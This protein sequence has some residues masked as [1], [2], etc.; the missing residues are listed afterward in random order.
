[1]IQTTPYDTR[2]NTPLH[3]KV[4]TSTSRSISKYLKS[5]PK[6]WLNTPNKNGCTPIFYAK[7]DRCYRVLLRAGA[8]WKVRDK[9]G[10]TVLHYAVK[11]DRI[12]LV[13]E[14]VKSITPE[15]M[16]HQKESS[17]PAIYLIRTIKAFQTL[18]STSLSQFIEE[19]DDF[20]EFMK[21]ISQK[22]PSLF[23]EVAEDLISRKDFYAERKQQKKTNIIISLL[24]SDSEVYNIFFLKVLFYRDYW[25]QNFRENDTKD[26]LF[27]FQQ[28]KTILSQKK[29][30]DIS[31]VGFFQ[32]YAGI[33]KKLWEYLLKT[34]NQY[35]DP[36]INLV[37]EFALIKE[38]IN[39]EDAFIAFIK[40]LFL[41]VNKN[42]FTPEKKIKILTLRRNLLNQIMQKMPTYIFEGL[43]VINFPK[44]NHFLKK[45]Y[46]SELHLG[47]IVD[48]LLS[49]KV[50]CNADELCDAVKVLLITG[51]RRKG[52]IKVIL[53]AIKSGII[54][55]EECL[56]R[57]FYFIQNA[58]RELWKCDFYEVFIGYYFLL[59]KK[60]YTP[61]Y[62]PKYFNGK[63]E[64]AFIKRISKCICNC[65]STIESNKI[66]S[67]LSP[68]EL[69]LVAKEIFSDK[70]L[71]NTVN[72]IFIHTYQKFFMCYRELDF[73]DYVFQFLGNKMKAEKTGLIIYSYYLPIIAGLTSKE[74][75]HFP[76]LLKA[77]LDFLERKTSESRFNLVYCSSNFKK[78]L[79]SHL[80]VSEYLPDEITE[81]YL[82]SL[83]FE[84]MSNKKDHAKQMRGKRFHFRN[85]IFSSEDIIHAYEEIEKAVH[86]AW[87]NKEEKFKNLCGN[88]YKDDILFSTFVALVD[89]IK[90]EDFS[91]I[92]PNVGLSIFTGLLTNP[93]IDP[94]NFVQ[95]FIDTKNPSIDFSNLIRL[96]FTKPEIGYEF[97]K[98]ALKI[99]SV[100]IG[101]AGWSRYNYAKVLGMMLPGKNSKQQTGFSFSS[102]R[103]HKEI[104]KAY[105]KKFPELKIVKK[106]PEQFF[107]P[108]VEMKGRTLVVPE[109]GSEFFEG[110]K[111][112]RNDESPDVFFKEFY[113]TKCFREAGECKSSLPTP[114]EIFVLQ[115]IPDWL[116]ET[117]IFD[118]EQQEVVVYHYRARCGYFTYLYDRNLIDFERD[119][120]RYFFCYDFG[121]EIARGYFCVPGEYFHNEKNA[122]L[123]QPLV[124]YTKLSFLVQDGLP[125]QGA[126]RLDNIFEKLCY[127]NGGKWGR[128]DVGDGI[129]IE[130]LLL[131]FNLESKDFKNDSSLINI[132]PELYFTMNAMAKVLLTD[133]LL[134]L[135]RLD[136]QNLI[137]WEDK[138][139]VVK[140]A[141]ILKNG[142]IWLLEGY[143]QK[144]KEEC[145]SF[146]CSGAIDWEL[147]ARQLLFWSQTNERGYP[148][149]VA[150][151]IMPPGLYPPGT[152]VEIINAKYA[153]NFDEILG[154]NTNGKKDIGCHN[155]P[156]ACIEFEKS[157]FWTSFVAVN[158]YIKPVEIS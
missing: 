86:K 110:F 37:V 129:L 48:F 35:S 141:S 29:S 98:H 60:L 82:R 55:R 11:F 106:V 32:K 121:I 103:L 100:F 97:A 131:N 74:I 138:K 71:F 76:Y 155:G 51:F 50:E 13:S 54:S 154:F 134:Q 147:A 144:S 93:K 15:F 94:K 34:K 124:D 81:I 68:K 75:K 101:S 109:K 45:F 53:K 102:D 157:L 152:P 115:N 14:L 46:V 78:I 139:T 4:K 122:R 108:N 22:N 137:D 52:D 30:P 126:G 43:R 79:A 135:K 42:L 104:R 85:K 117:D 133:A 36:E 87:I 125:P 120:G 65:F 59:I 114:I 119:R 130:D 5:C 72:D 1:M 96:F 20:D 49:C 143:L 99:H 127:P 136:D 142:P 89:H 113:M 41:W 38:P 67:L 62:N 150:Q 111:F 95:S 23:H 77:Q 56:S 24:R 12:S 25:E 16:S 112:L 88:L 33:E 83:K 58:T 19:I 9:K 156:L 118:P 128:R 28:A 26:P 17:T 107:M 80:F 8:D 92:P 153:L 61:K 149:Y 116:R 132:D 63:N 3:L 69:Y 91:L 44:N 40:V 146:I 7:T 84:H 27:V 140:F 31:L 158:F 73:R 18:F 105:H 90:K 70:F 148:G 64:S 47:S 39:E 57:A 123:Y 2:G 6:I 21:R 10:Q 151:G 66:A 145:E